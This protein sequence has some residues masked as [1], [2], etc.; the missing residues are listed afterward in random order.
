MY[1][2]LCFFIQ[3]LDDRNRP[4]HRNENQGLP[5][6]K[7][8]AA[9]LVL[10]HTDTFWSTECSWESPGWKSLRES[11]AAWTA[12]LTFSLV[13]QKA[14]D[15][16]CASCST[17]KLLFSLLCNYRTV[18]PLLHSHLAQKAWRCLFLPNPG[19]FWILRGQMYKYWVLQLLTYSHLKSFIDSDPNDFSIS[20][21]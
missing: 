8:L 16:V 13:F 21:V 12:I 15:M 19:M 6:S 14:T 5:S 10:C 4:N 1:V 9:R 7:A 11:R 18:P 20:K 3:S 2:T 17:K